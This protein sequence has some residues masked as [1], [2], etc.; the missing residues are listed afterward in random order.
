MDRGNATIV[1]ISTRPTRADPIMMFTGWG[2]AFMRNMVG[3]SHLLS[4]CNTITGLPQ[5]TLHLAMFANDNAPAWAETQVDILPGQTT[6]LDAVTFVGTWSNCRYDPPPE[7][8]SNESLHVGLY[9][10]RK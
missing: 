9:L 5:G 6:H 7:I 4:G 10:L 1:A 2:G 3:G 8:E